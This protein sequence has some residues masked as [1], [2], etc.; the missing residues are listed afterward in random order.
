MSQKEIEDAKQLFKNAIQITRLVF[1]E[2]SFRKFR[3]GTDED[4]NGIWEQK[5]N[6]ALYDV[7][8]FGFSNYTKHEIVPIADSVREELIWL[9]TQDQEFDEAITIGTNDFRRVFVRFQKWSDSLLKLVGTKPVGP[10]AFSSDL[11]KQLWKTDPTCK[12]CQQE[13]LTEDDAEVHHFEQYWRGGKTIPANARLTHRYCNRSLAKGDTM[14]GG[15]SVV[16][17]ELR[18]PSATKKWKSLKRQQKGLDQILE[19]AILM[20]KGRSWMQACRIVSANR[21]VR[22]NTIEQATTTRIGLAGKADFEKLVESGKLTSWLIARF[23]R[24]EKMIES[25]LPAA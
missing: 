23:P 4:P 18:A 25:A 19:V 22:Y 7:V 21:G 8:M 20:I 14:E 1:G 3:K 9:M 15:P 16:P 10:R 2:H 17:E 5:V 24:H 6:K 13:I 12:V 11:K